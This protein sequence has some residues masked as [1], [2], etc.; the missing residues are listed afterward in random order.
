MIAGLWW[1]IAPYRLNPVPFRG[2]CA[3]NLFTQRSDAD[4]ICRS[5]RTQH[6]N[7]R[8]NV[9]SLMRAVESTQ[10]QESSHQ[11]QGVTTPRSNPATVQYTKGKHT[12]S[13]ED[14]AR[15]THTHKI[16]QGGHTS[17]VEDLMWMFFIL[18]QKPQRPTAPETNSP[19]VQPT[20]QVRSGKSRFESDWEPELWYTQSKPLWGNCW[21]SREVE[22]H[23]HSWFIFSSS[24]CR[25]T[26]RQKTTNIKK[27][28]PLLS[29]CVTQ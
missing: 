1:S 15:K 7:T 3:E 9:A 21:E 13:K 10:L 27:K 4:R 25:L 20:M 5:V 23:S 24:F 18:G 17:L 8:E 14:E 28:M 26:K 11:S 29:R 2:P 19:Q 16:N 6:E 12:H 22:R